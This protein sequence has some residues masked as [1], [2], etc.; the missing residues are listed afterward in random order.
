[1]LN[2]SSAAFLLLKNGLSLLLF[3]LEWMDGVMA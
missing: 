2:G 3:A 1:M